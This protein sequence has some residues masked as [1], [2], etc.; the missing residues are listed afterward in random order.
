MQ[1]VCGIFPKHI[2]ITVVYYSWRPNSSPTEC[3]T[4]RKII[5]HNSVIFSTIVLRNGRV[6][7]DS[8]SMRTILRG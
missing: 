3:G 7:A 8:F 4:H 2:T 5:G 1:Q 6:M